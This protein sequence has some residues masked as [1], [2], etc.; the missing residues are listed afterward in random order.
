MKKYFIAAIVAT[1][2]IT[3]CTK[4]PV[5]PKDP[6]DN[7]DRL[8][9]YQELKD[10]RPDWAD[11]G[12]WEEDDSYFQ[13]G[14]SFVFDTEREAKKDAIRDATF[15]LSEHVVQNVDINFNQNMQSTGETMDTVFQT[16]QGTEIAKLV[17]QSVLT[18]V[19]VHETYT[20]LDVDKKEKYGYRAFAIVKISA[21]DLKNS[22]NRAISK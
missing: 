12:F 8:R 5:L 6:S 13:T 18:S 1:F 7:V 14:E 20:E 3:G 22:I 19:S 15:R 2:A 16:R 4:D 11:K 10:A 17:S 21:R 9:Y